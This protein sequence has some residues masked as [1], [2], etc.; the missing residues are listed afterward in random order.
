MPVHLVTPFDRAQDR[1]A[2]DGF[3]LSPP[4]K[5]WRAHLADICYILIKAGAFLGAIYLMVLGLPLLFFLMI[6]AGDMTLLFSHLGNLAAHYLA[7]DHARQASFVNELKL[8][9]FAIATLI[10]V[11]RLPR[12][13][14]EVAH[15]LAR[16]S[17]EA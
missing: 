12:F 11:L 1:E 4:G 8:G 17:A 13:L 15:G 2:E 3:V 5:T 7:A 10:A 9:L 14:D 16:R 6:A